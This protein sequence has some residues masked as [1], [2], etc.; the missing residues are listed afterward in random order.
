MTKRDVGRE[1]LDGLAAIK[2]G[3]GRRVEVA[4]PDPKAIRERLGL[5][6]SALNVGTRPAGD[7]VPLKQS[8]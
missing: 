4:I 8:R 1:I 7:V 2:R 6:Q 3:E 5:S